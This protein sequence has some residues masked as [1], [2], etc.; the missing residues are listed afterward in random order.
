FLVP[1]IQHS[2]I[3]P[4]TPIS[5]FSTSRTLWKRKDNNK[6][7]GVSALR[8]T[9]PRP[10]QTLSVKL[11]QVPRPQLGEDGKLPLEGSPDHGL[12]GFFKDKKLLQTPAEE[13][14]HGKAWTTPELREKS[15]SD[16]HNLWWVCVKERNRLA[17]EKIERARIEAGYGDRENEDRDETIQETMKAI[18][19]TLLERFYAWEDAKNLAKNDPDFDLS[20]QGPTYQ[21][22]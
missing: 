18:Q 12:W 8:H 11:D 5:H 17:T 21:P 20:G 6:N 2:R 14:R 19:D 1:S 4:Y 16:L 10:R 3:A 15:W 22:Q 9:G 7:R 13:S